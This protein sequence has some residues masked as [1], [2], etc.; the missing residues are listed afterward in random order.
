MYLNYL[1]LHHSLHH[2]CRRL[3]RRNRCAHTCPPVEILPPTYPCPR[4]E[5]RNFPHLQQRGKTPFG[6]PQFKVDFF[7]LGLRFSILFSTFFVFLL[8]FF[9]FL[10]L[11]LFVLVKQAEKFEQNDEAYHVLLWKFH[12]NTAEQLRD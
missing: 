12:N 8:F 5:V 9:S 3:P 11:A 6:G 4:E 1:R 10:H 7:L 2:C